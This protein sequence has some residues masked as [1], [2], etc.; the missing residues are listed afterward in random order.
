MHLF[1]DSVEHPDL[2]STAY[3]CSG[4]DSFSQGL[5]LDCKKGRCNT[6]GY[7]T[8]QAGQSK[9]SKQLFLVTRAQAPFKG[10]CGRPQPSRYLRAQNFPRVS[11]WN[12]FRF[13]FSVSETA[14]IPCS[15]TDKAS[16]LPR[17]WPPCC[18]VLKEKPEFFLEQS[19]LVLQ[20]SSPTV[21][22]SS[23]TARVP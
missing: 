13:C 4:M 10:E 11:S 19:V 3:L 2:Q 9:K 17:M 5:C 22:L 23:P 1:I 16:L 15:D 7:H 6:L 12:G 18:Q 21:G 14:Q 20:A 8:R